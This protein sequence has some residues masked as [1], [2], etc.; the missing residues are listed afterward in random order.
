[1]AGDGDEED[2]CEVQENE[3]EALK[4]IFG[5]D[6]QDL[7]DDD[8]WKKPRPPELLL[9]LLPEN[10][11]Q[12]H[13][14]SHVSV[15]L[16]ILAGHAY[17]RQQPTLSLREPKGLSE[18]KQ[19]ELLAKLRQL[20]ASL[21]GGEMIYELAIEVG[22]F[23]AKH[24]NRGFDSMAEEMEVRRRQ[25]EEK[26]EE[27]ILLMEEIRRKELAKSVEERRREIAEEQAQLKK[28]EELALSRMRTI[29]EGAEERRKRTSSVS[30][31]NI[32]SVEVSL[33]V[34]G[35][36]KTVLKGAPMGT[37]SLGQVEHLIF[38]TS[39]QIYVF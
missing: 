14:Q 30:R 10:N 2:L 37:N 11:T 26:R 12:G 16:H 8:V 20:A 13:I 9:R 1:M 6:C 19:L 25:E 35:Q 28:E 4:S 22:I 17:P 34:Y 7:R 36:Q 15:S 24:N 3:V 32:P 29:S 38:K 33:N 18:T 5:S 27:G 23:L 21:E 39:N 31:E